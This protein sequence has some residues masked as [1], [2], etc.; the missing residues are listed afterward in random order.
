V[1]R[2]ENLP[3]VSWHIILCLDTF[4]GQSGFNKALQYM[5]EKTIWIL[6]FTLFWLVNFLLARILFLQGCG[7][8]LSEF[9]S[10]TRKHV[11]GHQCYWIKKPSPIEYQFANEKYKEDVTKSIMPWQVNSFCPNKEHVLLHAKH[12]FISYIHGCWKFQLTKPY[13]IVQLVT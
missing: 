3:G 2:A 7:S 5:S 6:L 4:S 8:L 10:S 12:K 13:V 9:P 1:D 11:S